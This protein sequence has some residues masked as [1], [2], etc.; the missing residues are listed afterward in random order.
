MEKLWKILM[1]VGVL[2]AGNA[3]ASEQPPAGKTEGGR[4]ENAS[5]MAGRE[6]SAQG[7]VRDDPEF[8]REMVRA[9]FLTAI[10]VVA[11]FFLFILVLTLLRM[12]RR[13]RRQ[14]KIG[15]KAEKTEYIDAWS[16]Y[17]LKDDDEK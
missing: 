14:A 9:M 1:I 11:G 12:G 16:H 13:Q 2:A 5:D 7:D 15:E 6:E 8:Q 10:F 3:L 17:R 4:V